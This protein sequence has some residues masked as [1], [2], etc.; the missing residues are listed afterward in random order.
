MGDF[1][2]KATTSRGFRRFIFND[3][4]RQE[5]SVQKSSLAEIDAIW[6]GVDLDI[7][8]HVSARMHLSRDMVR[9]LLPV[10]QHFADTGELPDA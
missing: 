6:L 5:C 10:L 4:Y 2:T 8:R 7:H 9:S 3:E 1:F